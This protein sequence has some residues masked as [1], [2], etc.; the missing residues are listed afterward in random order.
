MAAANGRRAV[1]SS[2]PTLP[3]CQVSRS[4]MAEEN[5]SVPIVMS[6]MAIGTKIPVMAK[7]A[8]RG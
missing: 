4:F 8:A 3:P 7:I 1:V 5:G 6:T 2:T